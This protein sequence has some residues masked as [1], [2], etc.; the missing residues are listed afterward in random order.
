MVV[1]T[2]HGQFTHLEN[3]FVMSLIWTPQGFICQPDWQTG[4]FLKINVEEDWFAAAYGDVAGTDQRFLVLHPALLDFVGEPLRLFLEI[5]Q[6][7]VHLKPLQHAMHQVRVQ[8]L[9]LHKFYVAFA[10]V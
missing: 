2:L 1:N 7:L 6:Q 9:S 5:W 8:L 3:Y 10:V 4:E